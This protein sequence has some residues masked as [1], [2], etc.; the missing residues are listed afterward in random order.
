MGAVAFGRHRAAADERLLAVDAQ[1]VNPPRVHALLG[2]DDQHPLP[3]A[4]FQERIDGRT[5]FIGA[6]QGITESKLAEQAVDAARAELAHAARVMTLGALTTSIAHE[7]NQP[8][9]GIITNAT[10][11]LRMLAKDPPNL[12]GARAMAQRTLR[13]GNRASEVIQRLQALFARKQPGTAPVDLNDA[14]REVLALASSE[15]Q[16]NQ[17]IL[18]TD[19]DDS[20]PDVSVDRV[21]LQQVILNLIVNASEA[22]K[23][24]NDRPRHLHIAMAPDGPNQV[25]L[26]VRDSGAGI[27]PENLER[28]F[29]PFYS[30]KSHSMGIG[31]SISRSIIENH[32]SRLWATAN[33]LPGATFSFSIPSRSNT[34]ASSRP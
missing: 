10:T 32:G 33:G 26:S 30:T 27:D 1:H 8:L 19:F 24:V 9:S 31:L 6:I 11:C 15:P 20:L 34:E 14:A 28:L 7:V 21:Q 4:H 2:I 17:V 5:A 3:V 29:E 16:A 12:E 13:D 18:L 23:T 25:C 22:M